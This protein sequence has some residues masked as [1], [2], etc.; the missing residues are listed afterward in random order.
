MIFLLA[1]AWNS[2]SLATV[3]ATPIISKNIPTPITAISIIIE[4]TKSKFDTP[5]V[6]MYEKK[7][8]PMELDDSQ[9]GNYM[10][11]EGPWPFIGGMF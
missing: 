7:Y 1:L 2:S 8:G 3:T 6:D 5:Y 10:W 4:D 9:Y 11:D